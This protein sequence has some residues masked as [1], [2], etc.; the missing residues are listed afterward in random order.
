MKKVIA[1]LALI[2]A[3]VIAQSCGSGE[4]CPAYTKAPVENGEVSV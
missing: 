3:G 4:K 1:V 2:L